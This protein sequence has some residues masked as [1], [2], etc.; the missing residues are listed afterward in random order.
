MSTPSITPLTTPTP[1]RQM[2]E[3]EFVPA[4]DTF[5]AELA[6]LGDELGVAIPWMNSTLEATQQ[7]YSDAAQQAQAAADSASEAEDS[8][9]AAKE[10]ADRAESATALLDDGAIVDTEVSESTTWSSQK[11]DAEL[12]EKRDK[13]DTAFPRYDLA[14]TATI[15]TLDLSQQQVFTVDASSN[16]TLAFANEPGSGRAMTAVVR[17]MGDSGAI[18]WP[19]SI[20]WADGEAPELRESWTVV[21]LLWDGGTWR[22]FKSG[23]ED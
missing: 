3:D 10:E 16:R 19:A 7:A 5:A 4:A 18:T 21:A 15:N 1:N 6:V 22:G 23:G 8:N 12:G 14:S 2:E 9:Q 13:T 20:E 11:V 17:I